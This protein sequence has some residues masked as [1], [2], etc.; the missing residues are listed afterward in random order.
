[1]SDLIK[2]VSGEESC[3]YCC[4]SGMTHNE[5]CPACERGATG[6]AGPKGCD[7][8]TNI[9]EFVGRGSVEAMRLDWSTWHSICDFIQ[10]PYFIKGV[11]VCAETREFL[12]DDAFSHDVG[13]VYLDYNGTLQLVVQGEYL[14]KLGKGAYTH[15]TS[16]A[17]TEC[18]KM[19]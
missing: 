5:K 10:S 11:S 19:L 14:V 7:A 9:T 17:L 1:M 15:M 12:P 6:P 13:L 4:N 3:N 16:E 18:Y 8:R 2:N